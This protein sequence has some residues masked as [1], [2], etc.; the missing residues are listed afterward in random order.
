MAINSAESNTLQDIFNNMEYGPAAEDRKIL[1][2]SKQSFIVTVLTR[3][4]LLMFA[5]TASAY[6]CWWLASAYCACKY[7]AVG[8][9]GSS[10]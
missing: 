5:C 10:W 9:S 7:F 4:M 8:W 6:N 1:D 3:V 2:V